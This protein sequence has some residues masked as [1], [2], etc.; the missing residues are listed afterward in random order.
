[1]LVLAFWSVSAGEF[2]RT[3]QYLLTWLKGGMKG[4]WEI[5]D[6]LGQRRLAGLVE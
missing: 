6:Q 5:M 1:M 4:C 3:G 2:W